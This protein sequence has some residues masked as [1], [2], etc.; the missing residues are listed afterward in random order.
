MVCKGQFQVSGFLRRGGALESIDVRPAAEL[1]GR[2]IAGVDLKEDLPTAALEAGDVAAIPA[3]SSGSAGV[4][5]RDEETG[6]WMKFES[7]RVSSAHLDI[8]SGHVLNAKKLLELAAKEDKGL[9]KMVRTFLFGEMTEAETPDLSHL[10]KKISRGFSARD[11]AMLKKAGVIE[12][13]QAQFA[14]PAFKVPKKDPTKSRFITDCRGFNKVY[15]SFKEEKMNIPRLHDIMLAGAKYERSASIDASAYFFQF[16]LGGTVG[17][18]WFPVRFQIKGK[19]H[20]MSL[21]R[22]PMGFHLAPIIAQRTSNIIIKRTRAQIAK[23]RIDGATFAWVG[24]FIVFANSDEDCNKM[25][26]ILLG[27]L[28]MLN[29]KCSEVDTSQTFLGLIR[30]KG[31]LRLEDKFVSRLQICIQEALAT[32]RCQKKQLEILAGMIMWLNYATAR[33][34]LATMP[35]TLD[36]LR[37]TVRMG[38]DETTVLRGGVRAELRKWWKLAGSIYTPPPQQQCT[39]TWSDARPTRLCAIIENTI[40]VARSE[41]PIAIS[42]G[43]AIAA[44]WGILGT[45]G[46]SHSRIDNSGIAYAFAKG[47]CK[48]RAVNKVIAN[49]IQ[50]PTGGSITWVPSE[51]ELADAPTRDLIPRT[52]IAPSVRWRTLDSMFFTNSHT[53]TSSS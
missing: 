47:H 33:V 14:L 17:K 50:G 52:T 45:A 22:L 38:K 15:G 12:R 7:S 37:N 25:M 10:P 6:E 8:V 51:D 5:V 39:V 24:N 53:P 11:I 18:E 32:P 40:L 41:V 44:G 34:P 48:S 26:A 19:I 30:T 31:G 3:G 13:S 20:A 49:V 42:L 35:E 2:V 16:K 1:L 36:L 46:A 28:R 23:Q 21:T 29:V 4:A 43:E 9:E 27:Q